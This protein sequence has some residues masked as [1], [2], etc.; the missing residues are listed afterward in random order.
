MVAER[1][2]QDVI[3]LRPARVPAPVIDILPPLATL[4][5]LGR[6]VHYH[7]PIREV[8]PEEVFAWEVELSRSARIARLRRPKDESTLEEV[9][10]LIETWVR[11]APAPNRQP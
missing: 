8:W 10:D 9:C 1:P 5:M 2:V 6:C 11:N 4:K 3:V 7:R